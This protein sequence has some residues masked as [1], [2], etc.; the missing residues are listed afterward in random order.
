MQS[1]RSSWPPVPPAA[2]ALAP[3]Q[4]WANFHSQDL[5]LQRFQSKLLAL[6]QPEEI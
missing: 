6:Q 2:T 4:G 1:L 3:G 5:A